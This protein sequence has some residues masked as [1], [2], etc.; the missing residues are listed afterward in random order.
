MQTIKAKITNVRVF[1]NNWAI[2]NCAKG[3][4]TFRA[5]GTLLIEADALNG[6]VCQLEGEWESH[7]RFGQSFKFSNIKVSGSEMF[8]FLDKIV[9]V[10][11]VAAQAMVDTYGD[12]GLTEIMEDPSRHNEL[13]K[14]KGI[15]EKRMAK[16]VASWQQYRHIKILSD[17]LTPYGVSANLVLRVYT[18]FEEKA[19]KLIKENPF[20]LTSVKGIGFRKADLVALR[21]GMPPRDPQRLAAAICF[22]MEESAENNGNTLVSPIS[23][24]A[25]TLKELA[26]QEG[27]T[28][29]KDLVSEADIK[30]VMAELTESE[31]LVTLGDSIALSKHF[32]T[33]QRILEA[34][35]WR[36]TMQ[37]SLLMTPAATESFIQKMQ[38]DMNIVF[39]A[40]QADSL[41]MVSKGHRTVAVTGYA[42]VG[43]STLSKAIITMLLTKYK[44]EDD[45]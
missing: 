32:K 10:G 17:Y 24:V 8:F 29:D 41:R 19:I 22:V 7:P 36:G 26:P 44:E 27:V 2:L 30:T 21:L 13:L 20:C 40:E 45:L 9:H 38:K 1:N 4:T 31:R 28:D 37:P 34:I 16:V 18:K 5:T 6:V 42:G 33:E 39:S 25:A 14:V 15:G 11:T 35:E 43:K 12:G 23:I 3:I